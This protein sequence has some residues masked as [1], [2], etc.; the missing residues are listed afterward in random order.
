MRIQ[1]LACWPNGKALDYES[2]DCR[3]DPCVGHLFLPPEDDIFWLGAHRCLES[4]FI[5]CPSGS[6]PLPSLPH[7]T[8]EVLLDIQSMAR[9]HLRSLV[10]GYS[11]RE[12]LVG[13][14]L[15]SQATKVVYGSL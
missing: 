15:V 4:F 14:N 7:G 9:G 13:N 1:Q 2:R 8:P 3:F 12:L 11:T 5:S 10:A 6:P